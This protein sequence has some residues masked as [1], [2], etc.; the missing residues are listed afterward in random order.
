MWPKKNASKVLRERRAG[1]RKM[2]SSGMESSFFDFLVASCRSSSL[3]D[4]C[5]SVTQTLSFPGDQLSICQ[6]QTGPYAA[7]VTSYK[8]EENGCSGPSANWCQ[9]KDIKT[10]RA[11]NFRTL[12]Q[13]S[14]SPICNIWSSFGDKHWRETLDV[15]IL[16]SVN[17]VEVI[18]ALFLQQASNPPIETHLLL[19][20]RIQTRSDVREL[21]WCAGEEQWDSLGLKT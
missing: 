9:E 1:S 21:K 19:L 11:W 8:V 14:M 18:G 17:K 7:A 15:D 12:P 6:T 10:S 5:F 13:W 4:G 3:M 16:Q 20:G 2:I